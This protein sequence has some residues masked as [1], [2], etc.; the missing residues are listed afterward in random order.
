MF[1]SAVAD[2]ASTEEMRLKLEELQESIEVKTKEADE[3]LEKYC[4]LIV[5]FHKLEEAN[6]MLKTQVSLLNA[7]LK[8][9]T[10]VVVSNSPLLSLD[11]P[12]TVNDQPVTER[13]QE[14]STRLSGKRRR[15]QEIKENGVPRSPIPEILAKK[16]KKGAVYQDSLSENREYQ[17][18]GLPEVVKK[19]NCN[20]SIR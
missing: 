20:F 8:P 2:G 14:D 3:N 19:G 9:T 15:S 6:E 16:L 17:P 11:N 1:C 4:S 13:S 18:E 10:D 5:N 7:Q 12:V